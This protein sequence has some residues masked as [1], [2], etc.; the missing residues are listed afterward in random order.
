MKNK[1]FNIWLPLIISLAMIGGIFLG[2][3]MR[4]TIPD[5]SS[6][7]L[8]KRKPVEQIIDLINSKYVDSINTQDLS[9]T[10][11]MA[12]LVATTTYYPLM[13]LIN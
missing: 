7:F 1:K 2:Y 8:E 11:I 4:E 6:F 12:I 9:D 10:A 5:K 3:K 13:D